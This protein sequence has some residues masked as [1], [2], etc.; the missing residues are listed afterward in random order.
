MLSKEEVRELLVEAYERTNSATEVA[1]YFG[2]DRG[3]VYE[4][5][6]RK[7]NNQSLDVMTDKRGR[8]P[9]LS[10]Q[11]LDDIKHATDFSTK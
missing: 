2:V 7:K 11:D 5:V 9:K 1:R 6:N 10:Q 3:T 4:Y 8:K